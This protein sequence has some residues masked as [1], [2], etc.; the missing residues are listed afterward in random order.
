MK[1]RDPDWLIIVALIWVFPLTL[2]V[3]FLVIYHLQLVS[4]NLTTNE[5]RN[6]WR[7][8]YFKVGGGSGGRIGT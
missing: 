2:M 5:H 4:G 1:L 3:T 7:Y 8:D 6:F